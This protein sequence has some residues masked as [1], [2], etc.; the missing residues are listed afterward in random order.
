VARLIGAPPGY[1][2]YEEAGGLTEAVR[3]RP[4]RVVLFDEIEKAHVDVQDILLQIMEDGKLTDSQGR[5]VNFRNVV[6]ILTS[7]LGTKDL[8]KLTGFIHKDGST[9][10]LDR[11]KERMDEALKN[12]FRPEF[13]NRL[14]DII[15]FRELTLE[16][17]GEI[18]DLM[19]DRVE[20]QLASQGLGL[21]LTQPAKEFLA[22]DGYDPELGARPLRRSMLRLLEDPLSE[23]LLYKQYPT[24]TDEEG[25][26][27]IAGDIIVVDVIE[28]PEDA[29]R[30]VLTFNKDPDAHF[31]PPVE[32][33]EAEA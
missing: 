3:R 21:R 20:V 10:V 33:V 26:P 18:V 13:L 31:E 30:N 11:M 9:S 8:H 27:V 25:L 14:D 1:V 7:N 5:S 23:M 17:V 16:E 12:H 29:S 2:G 4:Y 6:L 22:K 15:Y 32:L 19:L 24:P 28:D